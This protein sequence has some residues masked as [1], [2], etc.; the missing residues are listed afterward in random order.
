MRWP[1]FLVVAF[2]ALVLEVSVRHVLE[3]RALANIS[4]SFTAVLVVYVALFA[5]R[6]AALWAAWGLGLAVDL[7]VD[8]P[9]GARAA[10]PIIGAHA[11]GYVF[12]VYLLLQIRGL[13]F[14]RQALTIGVMAALFVLAASLVIVFVYAVHGWYPGTADRLVWADLRPAG[15]LLRRLGIALYTGVLALGLS[16]PLVWSTPVWGFRVHG[17]FTAN[18]R[19]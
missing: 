7:C 18:A 14:R 11:L 8:L 17:R 3:L 12:G 1:V 4:P 13:L 9:I 19:G 2:I 16:V 15:E 5:T 10:G 6:E